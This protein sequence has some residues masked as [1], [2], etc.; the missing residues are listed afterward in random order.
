MKFIGQFIQSLISRFRNDVYL[1]DV[2]SGTIASG[3]NLGLDSNNKIVKANVPTTHDAV[4]LTGTPDYI[5]ISGQEITRNAIDL[6]QDVTGTLGVS[7]GGTGLTSISTLLNSN[8]TKSDVGLG[9][10]EDKSSATIRGEI[11]SG[12]IPNN[13]ADTSGNAA[14]ATALETARTIAGVSFDGTGNISLNN[15]AITNGAGYITSQTDTIDMGDGFV[16]E[17][18]DGTEV[19]ITENKEIK[20]VEGGGIDINFTDTST[21]SDTD[22]FDLTFTV[23][24]LNQDTT[25]KAATADALETA[26]TIGGVSFDGSANIDLPGVNTSGNQDTSGNAATATALATARTIAGV[27]FDGTGNISLN[28]NA[29]TNGA[30]YITSAGTVDDVSNDNLRDALAALESAGGAANENIT[31]G[32]DSGDTIVITGNLQVN[33]TTTTIDTTNLNVTDQWIN[34][35][36]GGAAADG[37]IVIEGDGVSFGW[38]NSAGRWGYL[39][40]GATEGQTAPS[41]DAFAAQV[42]VNDTVAAYRKNGNIQISSGDIYIYVE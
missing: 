20:F 4:T 25:G 29:I 38:D 39:S 26:R 3:G 9:N 24:T 8:T 23:Q 28:N 21:G 41:N 19:T 27:S 36:D 40:T 6:A 18:G 15:N 11:V 13:A 14:T 31:I 32:A 10:V 22:P 16:I 5:T 33:G 17:D 35:N 7:K 12:N 30:G 2:S 34:L 1:E 37:G 42:V